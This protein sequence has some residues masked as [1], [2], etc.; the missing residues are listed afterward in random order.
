[1]TELPP[2]QLELMR[3]HIEALYTHDDRLRMESVNE[4]EGVA[5]SRF[6]L[7]RTIKGKLWRFRTDIP[8]DLAVDLAKLG[9]GEPE[10]N[11]LPRSPQNQEA[12]IHLLK[13]HAPIE[14]VWTGPAYWFAQ[15]V[16][17]TVPPV[18]ITETNAGL[19]RG[20]F[21]DWLPDVPH[22]CPFMAIVEDGHA[23]SVCA[24]VR[25]TDA[26]HEAGVETLAAHRHN[27]KGRAQR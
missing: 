24:S 8:V 23:I 4:L 26:A 7:G 25:I 15:D 3:M 14:R 1:M 20:G 22:R 19:L 12:Y 13:S 27:L 2:S 11:E 10:T 21:E 9:R 17:T 6:F 18:E 16:V 5:A